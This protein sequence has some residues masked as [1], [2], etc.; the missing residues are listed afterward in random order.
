MAN[1]G[2]SELLLAGNPNEPLDRLE[3]SGLHDGSSAGLGGATAVAM[4]PERTVWAT[5]EQGGEGDGGA[6]V[7]LDAEGTLATTID[8]APL[9]HP[10][11]ICFGGQDDDGATLV[12]VVNLGDGSVVRLEAADALGTDARMESIGEGLAVGTPGNP[13]T[14]G[15]G[16]TSSSDLPQGGARGCAYAEGRLYVADAQNARIMRFDDAATATGIQPVA[17]EDTPSEPTRPTWRSMPTAT[18][19]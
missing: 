6:I 4:T 8:G 13:G 19:S 11:G 16:L 12:F 2:T 9:A 5:Y 15:D 10:G 7:V 1:Y 3:V 17:L 14:P 18:S